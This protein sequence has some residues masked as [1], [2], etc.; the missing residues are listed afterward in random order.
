MGD[1]LELRQR[2][3]ES[4]RRKNGG[5]DVSS[6]GKDYTFGSFF[7]PSETL[8]SERVN[9]SLKDK[10]IIMLSKMSTQ[11]SQ[12][13]TSASTPKLGQGHRVRVEAPKPSSGLLKAAR[14]YSFLSDGAELPAATPESDQAPSMPPKTKPQLAR[15]DGEERRPVPPRNGQMCRWVDSKKQQRLSNDSGTLPSKKPVAKMEKKISVQKEPIPKM[16]SSKP[17]V[18]KSN[19]ERRPQKKQLLSEIEQ[20]RPKKKQESSENEKALMMVRNMIGSKRYRVWDDNDDD[21][22]SNMEA[23]YDEIVKEENRSAKL[24]RK[25]DAEELRKIEEEERQERLRRQAKKRKL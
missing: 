25:E 22:I 12:N 23:N 10:D 15:S 21:D 7:G 17:E 4:I 18:T 2:L 6:Q 8:I 11:S 24:A 16:Q 5:A 9:A 20:R 1:C 13:K 14:D 3:K 19:V